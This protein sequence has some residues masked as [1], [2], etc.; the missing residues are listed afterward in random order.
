MPGEIRIHDHDIGRLLGQGHIG[1]CVGRVLGGR[2]RPQVK[3]SDRRPGPCVDDLGRNGDAADRV[4][5]DAQQASQPRPIQYTG[6]RER[7]VG[8]CDGRILIAGNR[9]VSLKGISPA[10]SGIAQQSA[11]R[12]GCLCPDRPGQHRKQ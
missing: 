1:R 6:Q 11:C 2:D 7:K 12:Y 4:V 8:V 9:K 10:T 5:G 3:G